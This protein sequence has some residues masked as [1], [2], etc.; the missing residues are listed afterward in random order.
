MLF[1]TIMQ[2]TLNILSS[3]PQNLRQKA[4]VYSRL[5]LLASLSLLLLTGFFNLAQAQPAVSLGSNYIII[6]GTSTAANGTYYTNS[7]GSSPNKGSFAS[8]SLG[9][10]DRG[11]GVLTLNAQVNTM[12]NGN[13]NSVQS[14]Q[15]FYR[16]YVAGTNPPANYTALNLDQSTV[17]S[18]GRAW[19]ASVSPP[20]LLTATSGGTTTGTAVNYTLDL[21]FQ[22]TSRNNQGTIAILY[23]KIPPYTTN[24][25]VTGAVATTWTG[26]TSNDWFTD[27]NWSSGVVPTSETDAT[28][29]LKPGVI[30]RYPSITTSVDGRIAKVRTLRLDKSA[31]T[32]SIATLL[33]LNSGELQIFGDFI[34]TNSGF[35]QNTGFFTLAGTNQTFDGY[36]FSD[37]RVQGGGTKTLTTQMSVSNTLTFLNGGGILAT[38]T[39]SSDD[40][41]VTLL[42]LAQIAGEN[43]T[44]YVLGFV[45]AFATVVRGVT[46]TYGNV[47]IEVTASLSAPTDPGFSIVTRRTGLANIGAGPTSTSPSIERSY[48]FSSVASPNNQL[49][50]LVFR[51]LN[52]ELNGLNP[53]KL[54][55]YRSVSGIAPFDDLNRYSSNPGIKT[56]VSTTI[57]GTLAATFTLGETNQVPLPVT[58]ISFTAVPTAQG[59][60]L[61]RWA[62]ASE[63]NNKGFGIE[64][65]LAS[66]GAWQQVGYL[67][68][69]NNSMG[70]TYTYT[71]KSLATA[72]ASPQAYYRLRQE[73]L[74]GKLNYSPV[75]VV[76]RT[77][78]IASTELVLSPVPVTGASISLTFAEVAQA[79]S[80]ITLT[81]MKGQRLLNFTT[82]AS[83]AEE[84][85][86]P[87]ANLAPGVYIV[88]VRMPDQAVRYARFVKM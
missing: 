4:L 13:N 88:S 50:T 36:A 69:G 55:F 10:F 76:A 35:K 20:N 51:Y 75:A 80:E 29:T 66:G 44:S 49:F 48:T 41:N 72:A 46:S 45:Q 40:Y 52:T 62:T 3:S 22:V 28:I 7:A 18:T 9:S 87:V 6:G 32:N 53:A 78:A 77:A 60:A 31:N 71:D 16:V 74:D 70:G 23:D 82:Q 83:Q 59:G 25:S 1:L 79:G 61:L 26:A 34:N 86:L 65:Q 38:N 73:D 14:V 39:I 43:E 42:S 15:L 56:V 2:K 17:T 81:D 57:T 47:G 19:T 11:T 67:A 37:F 54:G 8:L 12:Q 85:S 33:T 21:Y 24:F 68:S 63:T 27:S 58:L 30:T 84:L 64:R 5:W